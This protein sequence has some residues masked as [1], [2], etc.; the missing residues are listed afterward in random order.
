MRV[1]RIVATRD[2]ITFT[3]DIKA[4]DFQDARNKF[5]VSENKCI[6]N[7]FPY[8]YPDLKIDNIFRRY[9]I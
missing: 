9:C 4:V 8:Y 7:S 2:N 3:R 5:L 1:F 6:D